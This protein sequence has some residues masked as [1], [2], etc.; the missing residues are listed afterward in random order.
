MKDNS[1]KKRA[2]MGVGL[3]LWKRKKQERDKWRWKSDID[4]NYIE[5][6]LNVNVHQI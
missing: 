6:N 5:G 2:G 4:R 3:S 1:G